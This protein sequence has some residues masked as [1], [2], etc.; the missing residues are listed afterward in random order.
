MKALSLGEPCASLIRGGYTTIAT[1]DCPPPREQI[2][3]RIA[4]HAGTCKMR[5][6]EDDF[7][8][9]LAEMGL[10]RETL[11]Y[12][13]IVATARLVDAG[14]VIASSRAQIRSGKVQY[15]SLGGPFTARHF[16]VA[17]T[18]RYGNFGIERWLWLLDDI[19][20]VDPPPLATGREGLWEWSP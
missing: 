13:K 16:A 5:L 4:I 20:P 8:C 3:Q 10:S 9:E 2:G 11:P 15:Y 18:D 7:E 12:G 17:A 14:R 6:D 19:E 1:R